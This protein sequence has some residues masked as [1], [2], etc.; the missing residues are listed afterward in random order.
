MM[1]RL[2]R[3]VIRNAT[4]TSGDALTLRV[5]AVLLRSA[6]ILPLEQVEV[7]NHTSGD[8]IV[9][10]AEDCLPCFERRLRSIA[11][12]AAFARRTSDWRTFMA[13]R[14][15]VAL[16]RSRRILPEVFTVAVLA[17]DFMRKVYLG[18]A[19]LQCLSTTARNRCIPFRGRLRRV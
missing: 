4:V 16:A 2:V 7:V 8:R 15:S 6:G 1:R 19:P 3:A 17:A 13:A 11:A 12:M 10:F 14:I 9:T 18:E 5:D